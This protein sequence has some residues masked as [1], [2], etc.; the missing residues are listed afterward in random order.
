MAY[1]KETFLK[2]S[3]GRLLEAL[4]VGAGAGFVSSLFIPSLWAGAVGSLAGLVYF[5]KGRKFI[6]RKRQ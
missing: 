1:N 2:A 3:D 6:E 4:F 5:F